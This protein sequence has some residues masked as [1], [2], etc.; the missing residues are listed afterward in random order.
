MNNQ[1]KHPT[2][3]KSLI[4]VMFTDLQ[5]RNDFIAIIDSYWSDH[6]FPVAQP[7]LSLS[8]DNMLIRNSVDVEVSWYGKYNIVT[9][10]KNNDFS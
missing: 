7:Q 1:I 4:H 2:K 8:V 6:T 10:W 5:H 3:I 9:D